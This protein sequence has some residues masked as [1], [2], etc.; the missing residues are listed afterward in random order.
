[1]R[2]SLSNMVRSCERC[3]RT[4]RRYAGHV[5]QRFCSKECTRKPIEPRRCKGCGKSFV[6][7]KRH[8]LYC[9]RG[10]VHRSNAVERINRG[11]FVNAR[12]AKAYLLEVGGCS[13]C[14]WKEI[15]EV[16]ELHHI[17]RNRRNNGIFNLELLCPNCH[18]V[19][20]FKM[21]DGQFVN[22]LGQKSA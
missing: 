12:I 20:H 11:I 10:C 22:N 21:K 1:M 4:F 5:H 9:A 19:D 16:L 15:P 2:P 18:T 14:G 17:D 8:G 13:R 7:N 6:P 3:G